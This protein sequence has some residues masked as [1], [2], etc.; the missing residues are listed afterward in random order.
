M[1][2][3]AMG[4]D[5]VEL[6]R[7]VGLLGLP[8]GNQRARIPGGPALPMSGRLAVRLHGLYAPS[9]GSPRRSRAERMEPAVIMRR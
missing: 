8:A 9:C 2:L 6:R 3:P 7:R 4:S 5:N 1:V